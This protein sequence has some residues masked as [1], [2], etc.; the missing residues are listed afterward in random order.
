MTTRT[1]KAIVRIVCQWRVQIV[2]GLLN[3]VV[4]SGILPEKSL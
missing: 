2:S 3:T 4:P 1:A